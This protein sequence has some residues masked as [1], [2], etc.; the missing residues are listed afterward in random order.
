MKKAFIFL[1]I[2]CCLLLTTF[3]PVYAVC[4]SSKCN[5][6]PLDVIKVSHISGQIP[7]EDPC[8]VIT[9]PPDSL[10]TV[11]CE[12]YLKDPNKWLDFS[13]SKWCT[14]PGV[15]VPT[16]KCDEDCPSGF[17]KISSYDSFSGL[18][19]SCKCESIGTGGGTTGA[20][21]GIK[22]T[23][24][25]SDGDG[26]N[27]GIITALGCIPTQDPTKF[28]GWILKIAIGLG[29]GIAFLLIVFGAFQV[30]TSSGNPES[31]KKGTEMITAAISGLIFIIFSLFLLKLIGVN[32]LNI[33]GF[34]TP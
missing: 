14:P 25:D 2:V 19:I 20:S 24:C 10:H 18:C 13:W 17:N 4:D 28:A 21:G 29:G 23:E 12:G 6:S 3:T 26:K 5:A 22:P 7:T 34:G 9:K 27:D 1:S 16:C 15:I 33:P 31:V 8:K 30:I 11:C 32:I